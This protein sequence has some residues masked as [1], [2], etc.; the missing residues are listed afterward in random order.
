MFA[1]FNIFSIDA[2]LLG[3]L[4]LDPKDLSTP[5]SNNETLVKKALIGSIVVV[6]QS[7]QVKN[8]NTGKVYGRNGKK[9]FGQNYS[10]GVKTEAGLVLTDAALKPW[11]DD[12]AFKKVEDTYEPF[13]SL[14]EIRDISSEGN[15]KFVQCPLQM[16]RQ[17]PNGVWIA[18]A[19]DVAHNAMEIDTEDGNKEGCLIWC[20]AL[21]NLDKDAKAKISL[22]TV[23]KAIDLGGG[24]IS[25]DSPGDADTTLGAI[26]VCPAFLGG[27]HVAYRLVGL[28]A[29]EDNSWK[30]CMPFVGYSYDK[31]TTV[32]E[33]P[34][35]APNTGDDVTEIPQEDEDV[36]LTP[37]EGNKKKKKNK[38]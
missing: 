12:N 27:G 13:I 15:D 26:Y 24:E 35:D 34:H 32:E 31:S 14:T 17:Q 29:K 4:K 33:Q 16:G 11:L 9:E 6:K 22:Q 10:I 25:I 37:I 38:K 28:A 21:D 7:Y 19:G 23:S 5:Q 8:K 1:L 20:V 30:L 2:Q 36:E 18:N 3:S